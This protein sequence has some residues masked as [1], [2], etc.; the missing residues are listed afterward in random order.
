[1]EDAAIDL[2]RRN[3]I[4]GLICV[5]PVRPLRPTVRHHRFRAVGRDPEGVAGCNRRTACL[6]VPEPG[7]CVRQESVSSTRE[8][9]GVTDV[10]HRCNRSLIRVRVQRPTH[11]CRRAHERWGDPSPPSRLEETHPAHP[12]HRTRGVSISSGVA[13]KAASPIA[14]RIRPMKPRNCRPG[15]VQIRCQEPQGRQRPDLRAATQSAL[16]DQSRWN[17]DDRSGKPRERRSQPP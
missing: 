13:A 7:T 8:S 10:R 17:R 12:K 11:Q 1:M 16:L 4:I 9:T 15:R 6:R 14:G 2:L 3:A 5:L